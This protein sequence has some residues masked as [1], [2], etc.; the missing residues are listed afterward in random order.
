M[1]EVREPFSPEIHTLFK[2]YDYQVSVSSV[3]HGNLQGTVFVVDPSKPRIGI[4]M[5]PEGLF[6]AGNP[7]NQAFNKQLHT[8]LES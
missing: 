2:S 8:Y 4:M 1:F 3:L 6:I 7:E 5:N